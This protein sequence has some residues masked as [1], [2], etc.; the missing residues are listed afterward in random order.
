MKELGTPSD[1]KSETLLRRDKE[2]QELIDRIQSNQENIETY[3][4]NHE[5]V[6]QEFADKVLG[7]NKKIDGFSEQQGQR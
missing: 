7:F 5:Q 3:I 1:S 4:Q 2:I 6:K